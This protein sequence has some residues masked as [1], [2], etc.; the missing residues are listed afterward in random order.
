M[1]NVCSIFHAHF[2]KLVELTN[3]HKKAIFL[4]KCLYWW[5]LSTYTLGDNQIWFTRNLAGMA[6]ELSL[7]ERTVS[8]YLHDLVT[9]GFLERRCKLSASNKEG[10][11]VSK[12]L[13]IR[14]TEKLLHILQT[15]VL[16]SK[17]KKHDENAND[18]NNCSFLAQNGEIEK[19]TLAE[20]INKDLDYNNLVNNTVSQILFGDK[21]GRKSGNYSKYPR[22]AIESL[23]GERLDE[24]S[25][26]YIKGTMANLQTQHG[27]QFSA[28]EQT[29]AEIIF[30]LTNQQQ[31]KHVETIPHKVQ[32]IA[33]LLREKRWRT[34]KGFYNHADY[35]Q[36]FKQTS[37]KLVAEENKQDALSVKTSHFEKNRLL[38]Q[39]QDA[40]GNIQ[41]SI[42]S[43][44]RYLE[45]TL[46]EQQKGI[47]KKVLLDSIKHQ[48]NQ[49]ED[50]AFV[51]AKDIMA[52]EQELAPAFKKGP[53]RR[54]EKTE[55][56][57]QLQD[58]ANVL[59]LSMSQQF[60]KL[61]ETI[62]L[63]PKGHQEIDRQ[64]QVYESLQTELIKLEN[65][66]SE[67]EYQLYVH[68]AA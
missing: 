62:E 30:T 13:Y 38:K 37:G 42:H 12:R 61:C 8:R 2:D 56:L 55:Q 47:D 64:Q 50:E 52:L 7:S 59:R 57:N 39:K 36:Y 68:Q 27:I 18:D 26:N 11:K 60:E 49:L 35:G 3:S 33:K 40:L 51:L 58:K 20:S 53:D 16:K 66:I 41:R 48:L 24:Q 46:Q 5:Q 23:I 17:E 6:S 21:K 63:L 1:G 43:E 44:K 9:Q 32:I 15:K 19:V 54:R 65:N 22:Y 25:K 14:V 67:L 10:F 31:L 34:P 4:D 28:P 29:F 45:L